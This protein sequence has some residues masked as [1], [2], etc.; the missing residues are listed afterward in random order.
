MPCETSSTVKF[1]IQGEDLGYS[2]DG[3]HFVFSNLNVACEGGKVTA[4]IGPSGCGKSTL[5]YILAGLL[6]PVKGKVFMNGFDLY[7]LDD[8]ERSRMRSKG[9]GFVFQDFALDNKRTIIDNVVESSLYCDRMTY[10]QACERAKELLDHL[11]VGE[12]PYATP[13]Q[14]SGGQAQRVALARAM[15]L[16]PRIIFAD[17]PT[18]NLDAVA[19]Q[20]TLDVLKDCAGSGAAVIVVTHDEKV[21]DSC[22]EVVYLEV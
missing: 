17:E 2:Y 12:R 7:A 20:V 13:I 4:F 19:A 15:L 16:E 10:E 22:D 9:C 1:P 5:M 14:L 6:C 11:G 18:G 3:E 21:R 8:D